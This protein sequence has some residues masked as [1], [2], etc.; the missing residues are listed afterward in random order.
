MIGT[1]N[2]LESQRRRPETNG[3]IEVEGCVGGEDT[4]RIRNRGV[5]K[6]SE[7]VVDM[8]ERWKAI[9]HLPGYIASTYGRIAR[10]SGHLAGNGYAHLSL[11]EKVARFLPGHCSAP[12]KKHQCRAWV[13]HLIALTFLGNP[14]KGKKEINHKNRNRNDNRPENLEWTDRHGNLQHFWD[15]ALANGEGLRKH[16]QEQYKQIHKLRAEGKIYREIAALVGMS[17]S[18]VAWIARSSRR[19]R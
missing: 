12:D 19:G 4:E 13:H 16:T 1:H 3:A 7:G 10:I 9:P 6:S 17:E 5:E 18:T 11:P 14:P 8:E 15:D 2:G